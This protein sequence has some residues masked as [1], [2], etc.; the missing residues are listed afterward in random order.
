[1]RS[2]NLG[3]VNDFNEPSLNI[4]RAVLKK[5]PGASGSNGGGGQ[6]KD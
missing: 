6:E 2:E 1:M 3:Q 5:D 4:E